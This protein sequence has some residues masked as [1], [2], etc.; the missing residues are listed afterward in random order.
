MPDLRELIWQVVA[1]IPKGKVATYGQI[2]TLVG[3][4]KH[5]RYVGTT[6]RNL[7]KGSKLPWY[8][9]VNAHLRISQRGGGEARQKKLLQAEG[10]E[11]IGDRVAKAQRWE[12]D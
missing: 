9:V 11:F 2:A 5:S 3:F 4:P 8:R 7:P 12:T 10:I 1:M 6:L